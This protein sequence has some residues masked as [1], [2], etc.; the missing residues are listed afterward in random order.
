MFT[1]KANFHHYEPIIWLTD[2]GKPVK[3]AR[4]ATMGNGVYDRN[5]F[6]F[7][8]N[9][10]ASLNAAQSLQEYQLILSRL[11]EYEAQNPDNSKKSISQIIDSVIPY[12]AQTPSEINA[13]AEVYARDLEDRLEARQLRAERLAAAKAAKA[14]KD[15]QL[16][17][18]PASV[19]E[20]SNNG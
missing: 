7:S 17:A 13:V 6:G 12:R 20:T 1:Q 14:A 4:V 5:A 2:D 9:D 10:I 11:Q 3:A 16:A 8:R 19:V 18:A 15:S